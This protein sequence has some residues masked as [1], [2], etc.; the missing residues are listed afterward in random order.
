LFIMHRPEEA[1]VQIERT[2]ELDPFNPLF[3]SLYGVDL[4]FM[5]RY[6]KAIKQFQKALKTVPN[7]GVAADVLGT[8]YHQKGMYKKALEQKKAYYES[9]GFE[10]IAEA[11]TRVYEKAGYQAAWNSAAEMLEELSKVMYVLPWYIAESYAYSGNKE[12]T[13]DWLEKGLGSDANIAY[14]GVLPHIVDFLRDEPRYQALLRKMNLPMDE[15][16]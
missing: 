12:K 5:R 2:M 4:V 9:I 10:E 8:A 11:L 7:H 13:L 6:D 14:I 1:M 16:E 3:Q 15:K